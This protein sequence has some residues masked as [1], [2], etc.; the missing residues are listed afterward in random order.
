MPE[1]MPNAVRAAAE[2]CARTWGDTRLA[3][4]T[5]GALEVARFD[6]VFAG[7]PVLESADALSVALD[8]SP[9]LARWLAAA[10][11]RAVI[12]PYT[13]R[14]DEWR[15]RAVVRVPGGPAVPWD[16][17]PARLAALGGDEATRRALGSARAGLAAEALA[18]LARERVARTCA[19]I[20]ALGIAAGYD[21]TFA[22]LVGA[23]PADRTLLA[24]HWLTATDAAWTDVVTERARRAL[25]TG[26]RELVAADLPAVL[27]GGGDAIPLRAG[28]LAAVVR[29]QLAAMGLDPDAGGHVRTG[30]LGAGAARLSYTVAVRVPE[31]V[32]L[33]TRSGDVPG[34]P[35]T[36][37]DALGR[38]LHRANVNPNLS[39]EVRWQANAL[40]V[41]TT[42]ALFGALL[43]DRGWLRRYAGLSGSAIE[44]AA[45]LAA[46]QELAAVRTAAARTVVSAAAYGDEV[47]LSEVEA[48]YVE[49]MRAAL[50]VAPDP[51]DA[52]TDLDGVFTVGEPLYSALWAGA[53][54]R[55]L[56]EQF[57]EDWWR[58][59][60]T[61][62]WFVAEWFGE[63][64]AMEGAPIVAP[65]PLAAA[66]VGV[67][68]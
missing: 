10:R 18:P 61:G 50:G 57:D 67:L 56:R 23:T 41:R 66:L 52:M 45:R 25:G 27:A 16:D 4:A 47:S 14:A 22:R 51:G 24:T 55:R 5:R 65:G 36:Y 62:P 59:P 38:A 13:A 11:V 35:R 2:A 42:G 8:T 39:F 21:E 3:G 58:N 7:W 54:G 48:I 46:F 20:E 64:D 68:E 9:A 15:R 53:L 43:R 60:R 12:A 30:V 19:A 40:A 1:L 63:A 17:V 32:Y 34:A 33:L 29:T 6:A 49:R 31:E 44:R 28:A 37:L 26:A